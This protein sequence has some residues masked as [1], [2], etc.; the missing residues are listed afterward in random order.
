MGVALKIVRPKTAEDRRLI[1]RGARDDL[2][3]SAAEWCIRGNDGERG[4]RAGLR[5]AHGAEAGLLASRA[6]YLA[7]FDGSAT[8]LAAPLFGIPVFGTMAHSFVQAHE[9][10]HRPEGRA[11]QVGHRLDRL[12]L[13]CLCLGVRRHG[14]DASHFERVGRDVHGHRRTVNR[15]GTLPGVPTHHRHALFCEDAQR[16]LV[17]EG[18]GTAST[19]RKP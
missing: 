16:R 4:V 18:I 9:R 5:R 12:H 11:G 17:F 6:S 14:R 3:R 10:R 19:V 2:Q 7:G 8:A 13:D 1:N 15:P